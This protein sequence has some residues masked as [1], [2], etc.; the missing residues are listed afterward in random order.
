MRFFCFDMSNVRY[1]TSTHLGTWAMDKLARFT[2][3]SRGRRSYPLG[4]RLGGAPSPALLSLAGRAVARGHLDPARRDAARG[5][6]CRSGC[7]QDPRGAGGAR[8]AWM[9]RLE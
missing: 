3:L 2:L 5:G 6:S 9:S 8:P 7:S 4:L 1:I